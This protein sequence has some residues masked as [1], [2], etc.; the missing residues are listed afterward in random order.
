MLGKPRGEPSGPFSIVQIDVDSAEVTGHPLIKG[1][2]WGK[3]SF[4]DMAFSASSAWQGA[5]GRN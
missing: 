1:E 3:Y 4:S 2:P 5:S